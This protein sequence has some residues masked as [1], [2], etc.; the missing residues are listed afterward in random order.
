MKNIILKL[1]K[2]RIEAELK[3]IKD[4]VLS[5]KKFW[6]G[7]I[8][9]IL[10]FIN[11]KYELKISSRSLYKIAGVIV[12]NWDRWGDEFKCIIKCKKLHKAL[13]DYFK[14]WKV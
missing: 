3:E 9:E 8:Y 4:E 1:L 12:K 5:D 10:K 13:V 6:F 2:R 14:I 11:E 7:L